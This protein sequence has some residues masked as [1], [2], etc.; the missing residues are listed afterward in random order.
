MKALGIAIAATL[1]A[2]GA[3]FYYARHDVRSSCNEFGAVKF[4]HEVYEC[5][6]E[7]GI[8]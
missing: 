5:K 8:Q 4:G 1:L 2:A 6:R 3:G 7:K